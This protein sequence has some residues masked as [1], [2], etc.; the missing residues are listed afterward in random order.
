MTEGALPRLRNSRG[1]PEFIDLEGTQDYVV[2]RV[3]VA[4]TTDNLRA[5][6]IGFFW[7]RQCR[8]NLRGRDDV[9]PVGGTESVLV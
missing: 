3:E 8:V 1:N 6:A 7:W 4:V 2:I 9:A 5:A